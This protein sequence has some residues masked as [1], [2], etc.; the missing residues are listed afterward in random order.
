MT[1][2]RKR[3][4]DPHPSEPIPTPAVQSVDRTLPHNLDAERSVLGAIITH[5]EAFEVATEILSDRDFYRDA[6]ARIYRALERLIERKVDVDFVTLKEELGRV[7]ELDDVG[8]PGY[9]SSLSDGMPRSS[10]VKFYANIVREKGR[11]RGLIYAANKTLSDAYEAEDTVDAILE[12]ADRSLLD[13]GTESGGRMRSLAEMVPDL[14]KRIEYRVEHKGELT[15]VDIGFASINQE[16]LGLQAGDLNIIAA[17]PSIGKTAFEINSA[18]YGA[19]GPHRVKTAMFSLEMTEVQLMDRIVATIAGVDAMRVRSGMLGALDLQ[20][21]GLAMAKMG[22][23]PI[24]VDDRV[25]LK[26]S[27]I[28][29]TCRRLKAE[30]GLDHVIVD[31][32]QL[33]K[34]EGLRPGA[35]RNEQLEM[36][37]T[38]LKDLAGELLIPVTM[39]SQLSRANEK[40]PDPK[41]K[42][43][44]LRESGALEQIAALVAFLHRK[45]HREG[46]TTQFI[47]EKQRNGPTGT[48]NLTFNRDTQTFTDGGEDPPEPERKPRKKTTSKR[49]AGPL[50]DEPPLGDED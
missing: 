12:R 45:N 9:I 49:G 43:S 4:D 44:D 7:G 48:V 24:H 35:N 23:L 41:P 32:G 46:G 8:G 40:R 39:L 38:R 30:E 28:R 33:V 15:G 29:A 42:L 47:I 19:M 2:R 17:R 20:A 25:G 22:E 36:I 11:L 5:N 6:H 21:V 18:L 13:L 14:F 10:N 34:P 50:V 27:E 16:T 3:G 31:Y 26:P 37:A 1:A